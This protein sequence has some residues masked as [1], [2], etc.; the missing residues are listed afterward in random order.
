MVARWKG[1][2][3]PFPFHE[4]LEFISSELETAVINAYL[5]RANSIIASSQSF[6]ARV[7]TMDDI[8]GMRDCFSWTLMLLVLTSVEVHYFHCQVPNPEAQ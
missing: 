2:F 3:I 7:Q 1:I 5:Q 8:P 6:N 4:R